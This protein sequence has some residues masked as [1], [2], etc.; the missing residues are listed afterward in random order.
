M[1]WT[2]TF[3]KQYASREAFEARQRNWFDTELRIRSNVNSN[4]KMAHNAF[5]DWSDEERASILT[6]RPEYEN[7]GS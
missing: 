2:A 3:G 1:E 6:L 5:S 4:F 7:S